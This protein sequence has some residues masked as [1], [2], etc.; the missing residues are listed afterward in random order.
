MWTSVTRGALLFLGKLQTRFTVLM[1][2]NYSAGG[3]PVWIEED[4]VFAIHD[5]Q[6][7]AHGGAEGVPHK[8]AGPA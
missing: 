7:V 3:E 4:L 6:V 8:G 2:S 1:G 5:R